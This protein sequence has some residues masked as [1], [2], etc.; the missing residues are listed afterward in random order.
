MYLQVD[1]LVN[2]HH[3]LNSSKITQSST[4]AAARIPV[5]SSSPGRF[6]GRVAGG[7]ADHSE[8][9]SPIACTPEEIFYY[10]Q[11]NSSATASARLYHPIY[12]AGAPYYPDNNMMMGS[13][14]QYYYDN[15]HQTPFDVSF[16]LKKKM[17]KFFSFSL[18]RLL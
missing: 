7:R 5:Q 3:N 1:S 11:Y 17:T 16:Y 15:Q 4:T 6:A 13:N 9:S 18:C 2:D 10:T 14:S 12:E 8:D